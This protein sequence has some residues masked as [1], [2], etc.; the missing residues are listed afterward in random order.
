MVMMSKIAG[1]FWQELY[2]FKIKEDKRRAL[3]QV[4]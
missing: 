4:K 1:A 3:D 2:Y